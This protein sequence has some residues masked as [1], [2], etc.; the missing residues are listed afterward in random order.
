MYK[1]KESTMNVPPAQ[2]AVAVG[3]DIGAKSLML[4]FADP[5]TP[6]RGWLTLKIEY[7]DPDWWRVL[8]SQIAPNAVVA[9]EPTG[10]HYSAP[11][12]ALL[13]ERRV[14]IANHQLTK[15]IRSAEVSAA[16]NDKLDAVALALIAL[17][18]YQGSPPRGLQQPNPDMDE[19]LTRLRL[20]VNTYARH[21]RQSTRAT[22][23]LHQLAH[24][25][26]PT[27]NQRFT[28]WLGLAGRGVVTPAEIVAYTTTADF[29]ALH[30]TA[31]RHIQSLADSLP[32]DLHVSWAAAENINFIVEEQLI[33]STEVERV[34]TD[35]FQT[36]IAPPFN[37][38]T[39][40]LR[41]VPMANDIAIAAIHVATNG[42]LITAPQTVTRDRM[43]ALVGLN[44]ITS[45]SGNLERAKAVKKGYRPALNALYMWTQQLVRDT[46]EDNPVR[47]AHDAYEARGKKHPFRAARAKLVDTLRAAV[48]HGGYKDVTR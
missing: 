2:P 10:W 27:L 46:T 23:L 43:R 36:I 6:P 7:N 28:T 12:I 33:R 18:T 3:I 5:L 41:T 4:A 9:L 14:V 45:Q 39:E 44:P 19:H 48:L 17:R 34:R 16:K 40:L 38:V 1:A 35:I 22:N 24:A 42:L 13:K 30:G 31:R 15:W 11:I 21:T 20:L 29:R 47:R 26:F 25:I 8:L 37:V 32:T